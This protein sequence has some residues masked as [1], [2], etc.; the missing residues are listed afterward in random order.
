MAREVE[1]ALRAAA[2]KAVVAGS[3]PMVPQLPQFTDADG[4]T[5]A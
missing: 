3:E 4:I 2:A 1:N 5:H